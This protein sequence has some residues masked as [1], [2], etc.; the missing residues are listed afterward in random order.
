[1]RIPYSWLS[2]MFAAPLP[3]PKE[4]ARLLTMRSFEIEGIEGEGD[5]AV[6][7][8]DIL[9]NRA[10]DCLGLRY[11]ARE[12]AAVSGVPLQNEPEPSLP[13]GAAPSV[14]ISVEDARC[15]RFVAVE[16]SGLSVGPSPEW[17]KAKI[18]A[19][20]QRDIFNIVDASNLALYLENQPTHAFDLDRVRGAVRVRASVAGESLEILGGRKIELDPGTLVIADDEGPLDIAGV[21]GG[22]RSGVS[23]STTRALL[24]SA[25]F[26][27]VT[28]RKAAQRYDLRTDASKRFEVEITPE[29]AARGMARWA[30]VLCEVAA[31]EGFGLSGAFDHY[32]RRA[33]P[34]KTGVSVAEASR[35]LGRPVTAAE[36]RF[37]LES[38][39]CEVRELASPAGRIFEVAREAVGKPYKY[40]ASVL[41]DAPAA[42]D[43]S[44]LVAYACSEA[45]L[46]APRIAV[47]QFAWGLEISEGELQPG[48]LVFSCVGGGV[49]R[50][51]QTATMEY[52]RGSKVSTPDDVGVDHVGIYAGDGEVIH[53][54]SNGDLVKREKIAESEQF[55]TVVGYRRAALVEEP[56]LIA[57]VP[58]ERLDLRAPEDL[59]EEIGRLGNL[60]AL[61]AVALP[62]AAPAV[63]T[64]E[65]ALARAIRAALLP[66]GFYE[67]L[68]SSFS[69]AGQIEILKPANQEKPFLKDKFQSVGK[70][71]TSFIRS[72]EHIRVWR[73]I[74]N[75]GSFELT[76]FFYLDNN[77]CAREELVLICCYAAA[78][79]K[80]LLE[81]VEKTKLAVSE[82]GFAEAA[83]LSVPE[84]QQWYPDIETPQSRFFRT[85]LFS[86]GNDFDSGFSQESSL[87]PL[88]AS[89]RFTP[90]SPYPYS[91]RDV[92]VWVPGEGGKEAEVA[93][94]IRAA[95]GPL[96]V[97]LYKFDEF[98]KPAK[99]DVPTR[100]S[101]GFRLILQAAD[102]TLSDVEIAAATDAA[103]AALRAQGWEIR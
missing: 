72:Y 20:G 48:D 58:P 91:A 43:C 39:G 57:T 84:V 41:Y 29:L 27:A 21:K 100:T 26:D 17:L 80:Q 70:S 12:V 22:A 16:V 85:V 101:Y 9:P 31:G 52:A 38:V 71:F 69:G 63:A 8:A 96:L 14:S 59:I 1:M 37:A 88:P 90:L 28:V 76:K 23:A 6:I 79:E 47:D 86:L 67:V 92:A 99:D 95:A 35:L 24:T 7:D 97:K 25:N 5:A 56:R 94:V 30:D 83:L 10:H 32:P 11:V 4:L 64:G 87:V 75:F 89:H 49:R 62:E 73:G 77:L 50:L 42:F 2:E 55:K 60:E 65:F 51:P 54:T 19:F 68:T 102:R 40:G 34:Y 13:T 103:Y 66:L 98:T 44:S 33:H 82:L 74:E 46:S 81:L 18:A 61:E 53:A 93:G 3:A 15:R 36:A 78:K 45:G